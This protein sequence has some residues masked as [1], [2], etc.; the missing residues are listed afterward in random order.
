[1]PNSLHSI[2]NNAQLNQYQK[3][4]RE[5]G[6]ILIDYDDDKLVPV[7]GFGAQTIFPNG[8]AS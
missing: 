4:I 7:Y 8:T 5:V 2:S 1:M 3:V 6:D